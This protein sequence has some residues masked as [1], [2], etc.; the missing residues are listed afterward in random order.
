MIQ[1][2]YGSA[3]QVD[4]FERGDLLN[5]YRVRIP[6]HSLSLLLAKGKIYHTILGDEYE[7]YA[8]L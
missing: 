1:G 8:N 2:K 7:L 5:S 3:G 6:N 4:G